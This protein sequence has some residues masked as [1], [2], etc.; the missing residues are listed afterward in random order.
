MSCNCRFLSILVFDKETSR[1][2]DKLEQ[3][4][5]IKNYFEKKTSFEW[6]QQDLQSLLKL[7]G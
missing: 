7:T 1:K 3:P 4:F 5:K 6:T 2:N